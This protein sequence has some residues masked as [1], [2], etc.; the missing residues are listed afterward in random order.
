MRQGGVNSPLMPPTRMIAAVDLGT[1]KTATAIAEVSEARG[2]YIHSLSSVPTEGMAKG[3]V[4]DLKAVGLSVYQSFSQA[5]HTVGSIP[6]SVYFS[7]SGGSIESYNLSVSKSLGFEHGEIT[8]EVLAE[9]LELIDSSKVR[10]GYT[11]VGA[12]PQHYTLDEIVAIKN[13]AGMYGKEITLNAHAIIAQEGHVRNLRRAVDLTKLQIQGFVLSV[14]G[15]AYAVIKEEESRGGVMVVDFGG[16]T[17]DLAILIDGTIQFSSVIPVG[18]MHLDNDLRQGLG[19]SEDE[20]VRL[21]M[22]YG[23]IRVDS[24]NEA[25]GEF[26]DIKRLGKRDYEKVGKQEIL[27]ILEP[28]LEELIDLIDGSVRASG[29]GDLIAGGVVLVG[30]G[31]VVRGFKTA[32]A[33]RLGVPVRVGYPEGFNHLL[34][35]YRSPAYATVLGMLRYAAQQPQPEEEPSGFVKVLRDGLDF[36]V[37]LPAIMLG[38]ARKDGD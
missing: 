19:V 10:D 25:A 15:S 35:G 30:G 1:S 6:D 11:M 8:D 2:I 7:I 31:A 13:P 37:S 21:K 33:R 24:E 29:L 27:R 34:E 5:A 4:R 22:N 9:L 23:R 17:T 28:R 16:G 18:G 38:K 12:V 20:A 14:L 26:V 32:L 3:A 36:L